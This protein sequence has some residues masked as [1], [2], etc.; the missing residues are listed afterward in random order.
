M[1][2]YMGEIPQTGLPK[3]HSWGI[4]M[5]SVSNAT[6]NTVLSCCIYASLDRCLWLYVLS[7]GLP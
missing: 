3:V 1:N 2:M 4:D 6:K 5:A 7:T